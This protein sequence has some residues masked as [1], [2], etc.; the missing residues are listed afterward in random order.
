MPL[1]TAIR[2]SEEHNVGRDELRGS[3]LSDLGAGTDCQTNTIVTA[4]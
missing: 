1:R 2:P 3:S 4:D